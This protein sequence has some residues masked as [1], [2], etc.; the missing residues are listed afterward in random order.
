VAVAVR[1]ARWGL[2]SAL[3]NP[4]LLILHVG[5]AWVAIGL[6]LRGVA[7]ITPAV[8]PPAGTHAIAAGAVGAL[9]LGML[10]RVTKGH[11]GR[12]LENDFA[13]TAA[14]VLV[15]IAAVARVT[16]ALVPELYEPLIELAGVAFASAFALFAIA[17]MKA[18]V[19]LRADGKPG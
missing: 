6:V 12:L 15:S 3:R 5:H 9:T 17:N 10:A 19:M 14:F 13:S 16:A 4:L 7:A 8:P 1:A 11:T 2:S 18:L